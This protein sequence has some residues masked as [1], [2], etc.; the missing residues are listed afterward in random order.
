MNGYSDYVDYQ[1]TGVWNNWKIV[2]GKLDIEP[3]YISTWRGIKEKCI[4][5]MNKDIPLVVFHDWGNGMPFLSEINENDRIL[6][7]KVYAPEIFASGSVFAWPVSG[8]GVNYRSSVVLK[9]TISKLSGWYSNNRSLYINAVW[10]PHQGINLKGQ[11]KLVHTVLD[12]YGNA[13]DTLKKV[14][15]LIN[16][17][18]DAGRNLITRRNFNIRVC[19][20]KKPRSVWSVSPDFQD[21]ILLKYTPDED[22]I[23]ITLNRLTAYTVIVLDYAHKVPQTIHFATIPSPK[24][25]NPDFDPGAYASSGLAVSYVSDNVKVATI[26]NGRIHVVGEGNCQIT[27]IQAGNDF[28]EAAQDA[29]QTF[30]VNVVSVRDEKKDASFRIYPNPCK[31]SIYIE[32]AGRESAHIRIFNLAGQ[33]LVDTL[34]EGNELDVSSLPHGVFIVKIDTFSTYLVK[35]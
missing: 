31:S 1:T 28:Y 8:G 35:Q 11:Q 30:T 17:N 5:R 33:I 7:L 4:V 2:S 22:S 34:I 21:A 6:W 19:S 16:K 13:G 27:A 3:S 10:N 15:H 26:V 32:R 23:E 25:G 9:D 20:P 18:L 12:L 24:P 14:I 29:H